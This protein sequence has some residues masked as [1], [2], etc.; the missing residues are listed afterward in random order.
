LTDT[1]RVNCEPT[2]IPRAI[3]PVFALAAMAW[4]FLAFAEGMGSVDAIYSGV[5]I[6]GVLVS[7]T[8]IHSIDQYL[9][10]HQTS[11]TCLMLTASLAF[12]I[13]LLGP[14]SQ[15]WFWLVDD[16]EILTSLGPDK[17]LST[18]ELLAAL[19]EH[20]EVLSPDE[21]VARYRP[22]YY[23]CKL[24]ETCL[25]GDNYQN[26]ARARVFYFAV[27]VFLGWCLLGSIVGPLVSG[28]LL[29]FILTSQYWKDILGRLGASEMYALPA[30]LLYFVGF[31]RE[32]RRAREGD[33]EGSSGC[34][35]SWLM[36]VLGNAVAAGAKE[37]FL[38]LLPVTLG[39]VGYLILMNKMSIFAWIGALL[40]ALLDS[41]I[42]LIVLRSLILAGAD[43]YLNAVSPAARLYL[44]PD[45]ISSL[46]SKKELLL[47][48]SGWAVVLGFYYKNRRTCSRADRRQV[49]DGLSLFLGLVAMYMSQ[50]FFYNGIIPRGNRYDFPALIAGMVLPWSLLPSFLAFLDHMVPRSI[51][52]SMI[53][54][55]TAALALST[56]S[57][58]RTLVPTRN[59]IEI[60][61]GQT[62]ALKEVVNKLVV[63][64]GNE[65]DRALILVAD[66]PY[67]LELCSSMVE[68]LRYQGF[69]NPVA[70]EYRGLNC[71]AQV[72]PLF[73]SLIA[74]LV[75]LMEG[76][77][78][79]FVPLD[80]VDRSRIPWAIHF[81][82]SKILEGTEYVASL[83]LAPE[84]APEES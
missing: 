48:L 67:D 27:S 63:L 59:A 28:Y 84:P 31:V 20:P 46:F 12:A 70:V 62:N 39:L 40:I 29:V 41:A 73:K 72:S 18:Q 15:G 61:V 3:L 78:H 69:Q 25:W 75:E 79:R 34:L 68:H 4:P 42:V 30:I 58:G 50:Y 35:L 47:Y 14:L 1:E 6:L 9:L 10:K 71:P 65:P 57:F 66:H 56:L 19:R 24:I 8:W 13:Y 36:L 82:G 51:P 38:I 77:H 45:S 7:C 26:W 53:L 16:H 33:E 5:F 60:R 37:N 80:G 52:A 23:G 64:G 17:I 76:K 32:V 49:M 2:D 43:S 81:S 11:K 83:T 21:S 54:R 22:S 55:T 74:S 44:I